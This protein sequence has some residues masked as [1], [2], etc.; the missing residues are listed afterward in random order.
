M[1]TRK[2]IKKRIKRINLK[3]N[4][5]VFDLTT[6]KNHNFFANN[7][8][9]HNCG[10]IGMSA[11]A[12]CIL[13]AIN[14]KSFVQNPYTDNAVFD[15]GNFSVQCE[16]ASNLIDDMIDLEIEKVDKIISKIESDVEDMSIKERELSV[17]NKIRKEYINVRRVGLGILGLADAIAALGIEYNSEEGLQKIDDIMKAFHMNNLK[18]QAR[19]A[20]ERGAFEI[21]NY[22]KEEIMLNIVNI[23]DDIVNNIKRYGRRNIS[24][25]TIAPTGSLAILTQTS[26]GCEPIFMKDYDRRRKVNENENLPADK[27]TIDDAGVKWTSFKVYHKGQEEWIAANPDKDLKESPYENS[28]AGDIDAS[29]RV[30][31]QGIMQQYITHSISSTVNLPKDVEEETISNI[32]MDAWK[33]GCKGITV[34]RD[35]SRDGIMQSSDKEEDEDC[36]CIKENHAP[37]RDEV[38]ECDIQ[39]SNIKGQPWIFFIGLKNGRPYDIFGG[40]RDNIE[41]PRKYKTGWIKKNGKKAGVRTYNLYL[42][43]LEDTENQIIINDIASVFSP[44][45]GSY[46][47]LISMSLRHGVP[48]KYICEQ[49]K[50]IDADADMF[51]FDVVM[52]RMLKKYIKEGEVSGSKCPECESEMIYENGCCVCKN[53]GNSACS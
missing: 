33:T 48:I 10:E 38:L 44:D 22:D 20:K 19:L 40:K 12:A 45:A 42:D 1:E 14:L 34:Y 4:Q 7:T 28:C 47:R 17:W 24:F 53:C 37:K 5:S 36:G 2:I 30:G 32:Y 23:N 27:I 13:M 49:L 16:M 29:I 52:A 35:G 6:E 41:I 3:T 46:T 21:F 51:S 26:S 11:N 39:F 18:N 15:Y 9:V 25:S 50:K 31:A 8:L 43:S